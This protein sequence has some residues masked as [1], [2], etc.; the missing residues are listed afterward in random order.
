MTA[1]SP[2]GRSRDEKLELLALLEEKERRQRRRK[3]LTYFPDEGPLRRELYRKHMQF[4]AAGG[5][6]KPMSCCPEDCDGSPHLERLFLAANQIGKTESA[7]GYETVLHL[8]GAYPAW[9]PGMRF[10]HPVDWW[11]AGDTRQ[12]TR[13]IQQA[14]LL[15]TNDIRESDKIGTGLIP[16]DMIAG[17]VPMQGFA[18]AVEQV[19]VRHISGGISN[20]AI[21]SYDQ[22]RRSFQGTQK[23]G[24]WL[25]EEVPDDIY[26]ECLIRTLT[27]GGLNMLT[28]TPLLGYTPVV[29]RFL[30]GGR[31]P[32]SKRK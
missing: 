17:I 21:K 28:F 23:H 9:W 5:R 30:P 19:R 7:G 22:G 26:E 1:S 29:L 12:T 24:I 27:T 25:D 18:G 8:T 6:H 4:F 16:G 31:P 13:D 14:K 2:K 11:A 15:G 10:T 3:I 20:L 32:G